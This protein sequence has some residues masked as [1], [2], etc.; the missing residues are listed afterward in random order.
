MDVDEIL[1]VRALHVL[2][3]VLWIGGVAMET[4]VLLPVMRRVRDHEERQRWFKAIERSFSW[5]ARFTTLLVGVTGFYMLFALDGWGRFARID[6]FW[7]H[8]MVMLWAVFTLVLFVLEPLV[9]HRW[10]ERR[11]AIDHDGTFTLIYRLHWVLL[12][13]SL[14]VIVAGIIGAHGGRFF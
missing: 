9:L 6:Q 10:F 14:L 1:I 12:I 8:A 13:V 4:T 11:V 5:Q 3:V 7:L 2:G